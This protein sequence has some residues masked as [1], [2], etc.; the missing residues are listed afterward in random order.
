M[1]CGSLLPTPGSHCILFCRLIVI[2]CQLTSDLGLTLAT[3]EWA[4]LS[5]GSVCFVQG[6]KNFI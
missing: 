6:L 5:G 3:C 4:G 1:H 2:T